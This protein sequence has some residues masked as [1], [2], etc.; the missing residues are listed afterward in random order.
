VFSSILVPAV[1]EIVLSPEDPDTPIVTAGLA[2][3]IVEWSGKGLDANGDPDVDRN[4][5]AIINKRG[6]VV[7]YQRQ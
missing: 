1:G 4:P 6:L 7:F 5:S 2:S 3:V